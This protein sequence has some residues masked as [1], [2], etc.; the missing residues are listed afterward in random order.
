MKIPFHRQIDSNDCGLA[1]LRMVAGFYGRKVTAKYLKSISD[2]TKAGISMQGLCDCAEDIGFSCAPLRIKAGDL[3]KAPRPAI[4]YYKRGHFVV[5]EKVEDDGNAFVVLD[6]AFGR[7]RL[8]REVLIDR[9]AGEGAGLAILLGRG[10]DWEKVRIPDTDDSF[11]HNGVTRS[12][13]RQVL[14][15]RR[16]FAAVAILTLVVVATNWAMPMILKDTIDKGIHNRD[17]GQVVT[18][19]LFQLLFFVGYMVSDWVTAFINNK[20]SV[21]INVAFVASYLNK[22]LRL[23]MRFFDAGQRTDLF[24]RLGDQ[25]RVSSF[26]TGNLLSV[27]FA[28]VNI[29]VFSALL[30]H[31]SRT[32][33]LI[34]VSFSGLSAAYNAYF[35]KRRR[36]LDY[37][38]FSLHS[39]RDNSIREMI[40]GTRPTS[41]AGARC[42]GP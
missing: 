23:P 27:A 40:S 32:V 16:S 17:V 34:F 11:L 15:N 1:C 9:W 3:V 36:T 10:D 33:F 26:I 25:E 5:L 39:E 6:P 35:L 2:I 7:V 13:L 18:L 41:V 42:A 30:I 31:N 29:L 12:I 38:R 24:Y 37:L 20:V 14:D 8:S 4:L 19:L 28:V 21:R 22:I